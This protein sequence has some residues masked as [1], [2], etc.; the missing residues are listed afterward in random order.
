MKFLQEALFLFAL[1][2]PCTLSKRL[3]ENIIPRVNSL[4][5][6][7]ESY[8]QGREER[9]LVTKSLSHTWD[10]SGGSRRYSLQTFANVPVATGEVTMSFTYQGDI[11]YSDEYAMVLYQDPTTQTWKELMDL[12]AGSGVLPTDKCGYASDYW[13]QSNA[14]CCRD[15]AQMTFQKDEFNRMRTSNDSISFR[16]LLT[17][18]VYD[19]CEVDRATFNLSIPYNTAP[20]ARCIPVTKDSPGGCS[21]YTDYTDALAKEMGKFSFDSEGD[22]LTY[23]LNRSYFPIGGPYWVTL[24]VR[25]KTKQNKL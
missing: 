14:S 4:D 5:Y 25:N 21:A 6:Q 24:T 20:V 7:S 8:A 2:A 12:R 18:S 1:S 10:Y 11:K 3:G 15:T 22:N 9:N 16:I 23:S 13:L 17:S 19:Y